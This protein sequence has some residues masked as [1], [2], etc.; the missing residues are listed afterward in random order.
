[1][2]FVLL[3]CSFT[4]IELYYEHDVIYSL[5]LRK[6]VSMKYLAIS[7]F[8]EWDLAESLAVE[9]GLGFE[10]QLFTKNAALSNSAI[11]EEYAISNKIAYQSY[12]GPFRELF[13][14]CSTK[15]EISSAYEHYTLFYNIAL[16]AGA[17]HVVFHSG[18]LADKMDEELWLSES[19]L[20]WERFLEDKDGAVEIHIE[21]V[22]EPGFTGLNR[23]IDSLNKNWVKV[24]LDIGHA[25]MSSSI[26]VEDWVEGLGARIGS[27]HLHNNDGTGDHHKGIA[28][29]TIDIDRVLNSLEKYAP[30]AVWVLETREKAASLKWLC[31]KQFI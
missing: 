8:K 14:V 21:N 22:Y 15:E 31:S 16:E 7:D 4:D 28:E 27:V 11:Q 9:H 25:N 5:L 10:S 20:F 23:L 18:F 19:L 30:D 3:S 2:F 29:G 26:P 12:H 6:R 13:H 1:M 24:C 17:S